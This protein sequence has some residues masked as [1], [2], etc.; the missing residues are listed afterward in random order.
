MNAKSRCKLR[1][2][3]RRCEHRSKEIRLGRKIETTLLNC[4]ESVVSAIS[5]PS[6]R[7]QKYNGSR[8]FQNAYLFKTNNRKPS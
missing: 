7:E 8:L 5:L 3:L 6:L 2:K 1:R 4:S